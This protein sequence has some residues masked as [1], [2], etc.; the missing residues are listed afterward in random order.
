VKRKRSAIRISPG[1]KLGPAGKQR[2]PKVEKLK[3][4][5]LPPPERATGRKARRR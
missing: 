1:S 2:P 5:E 4:D 3:G